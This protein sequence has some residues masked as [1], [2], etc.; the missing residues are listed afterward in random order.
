M[1]LLSVTN[2][3]LWRKRYASGFVKIGHFFKVQIGKTFKQ[4][5]DLE[6]LLVSF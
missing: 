1:L 5:D 6:I 3:T 2:Q 4:H